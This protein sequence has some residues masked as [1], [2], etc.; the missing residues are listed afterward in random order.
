MFMGISHIRPPSLY[1]VEI[2]SYRH[3]RSQAA[4]IRESYILV[5]CTNKFGSYEE[6]SL[7]ETVK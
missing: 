6:L 7:T 3:S 5:R 4:W 1:Q 2:V